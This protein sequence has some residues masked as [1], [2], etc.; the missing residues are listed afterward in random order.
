MQP[1]LGGCPLLGAVISVLALLANFGI[2]PLTLHF[3]Y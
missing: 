1:R 3:F 2:F